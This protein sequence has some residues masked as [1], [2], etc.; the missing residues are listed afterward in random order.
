MESYYGGI[1]AGGTK[2]VCAVASGPEDI[3]S[4]TR[5]PTTTPQEAIQ[6]AIVF[7]Q[8]QMQDTPLKGI[9]VA[10]FGPVD[11]NPKSPTFGYITSTPKP[12]WANA[13]F[14]ALLRSAFDL[15]LGFD[16]DVNGAALAESLWGAGQGKDPVLYLTIGTGIGGGGV[17][18]GQLMHGALHPEMGHMRLPHDWD[19][20]PYPGHC[21]Y[22]GDCLEGLA[23]GPAIEDR[24]QESPK[25]F[26][27]EHPAWELE[28]HYLA[29]ALVNLIC[30]IS[31]ERIILGGGVMDQ[32]HLFPTIRRNTF[33]LLN[34]YLQ[35]P[36]IQK[37]LNEYIVPPKLGN[38]VG[39]LGAIAL[40]KLA[41]HRPNEGVQ[42]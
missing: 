13:D 16:T 5:F 27:T 22:H 34:N 29:L 28:A 7:F 21:P 36:A 23:A 20:D 12:G 8:S 3:I 2:F 17:I 39:V 33:K 41:A 26:P 15:P 30:T 1:E 10:S 37:E 40:A 9:G 18:N 11:L 31:P 35:I 14:L 4:E 42:V 25:N 32:A 6:R 38:K 24:W 19:K